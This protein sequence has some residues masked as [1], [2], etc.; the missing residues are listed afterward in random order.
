MIYLLSTKVEAPASHLATLL[1]PLTGLR[2]SINSM[3]QDFL[4]VGPLPAFL[5]YINLPEKNR[6]VA[7]RLIRNY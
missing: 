2:C 3:R 6:E 1:E 7:L 5:F 4:Q